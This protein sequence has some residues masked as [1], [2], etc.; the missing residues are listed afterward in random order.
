MRFSSINFSL[1]IY[2]TLALFMNYRVARSPLIQCTT[3]Q[4]G[5]DTQHEQHVTTNLV[6]VTRSHIFMILSL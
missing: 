1:M 6:Q 3:I 5:M 4:S 2:V